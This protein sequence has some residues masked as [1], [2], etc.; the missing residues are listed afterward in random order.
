MEAALVTIRLTDHS[1][2]KYAPIA[3]TDIAMIGTQIERGNMNRLCQKAR[4]VRAD[5]S[6]VGGIPAESST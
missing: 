5:S 4:G 6:A 2:K 1:L 3:I